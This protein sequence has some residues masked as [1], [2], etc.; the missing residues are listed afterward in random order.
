[1]SAIPRRGELPGE[2]A[3]CL[4]FYTRTEN[5]RAILAR[6]ASYRPRWL[7]LVSDGPNPRHP[8]HAALVQDQTI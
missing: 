3:V 6:V 4:W 7:Y 1:M 2:T 8:E 5:V